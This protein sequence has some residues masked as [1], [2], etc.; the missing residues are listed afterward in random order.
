MKTIYTVCQNPSALPPGP[1]GGMQLANRGSPRTRY[2]QWS[3]FGNKRL[4]R[5][6]WEGVPRFPFSCAPSCAVYPHS[7]RLSFSPSL[8]PACIPASLSLSL[9]RESFS[10]PSPTAPPSVAAP[11]SGT[12]GDELCELCIHLLEVPRAKLADGRPLRNEQSH[13]VKGRVGCHIWGQWGVRDVVTLRKQI[14]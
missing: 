7:G 5:S 1:R 9:S 3:E 11:L 12:A 2:A 13:P 6:T 14:R 4:R 10:L 8:Q